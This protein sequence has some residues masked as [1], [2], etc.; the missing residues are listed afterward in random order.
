WR[1]V[2]FVVLAVPTQMG[3]GLLLAVMLDRAV[4]GRRW[5]RTIFFIPMVVSAV[6]A[7]LI[8]KWMLATT[9]LQG[10]VPAVFHDVG[11]GFPDWQTASGLWAMI[12]VV[13][14]NTWKSA[15]FCMVLYLAGLQSIN[16][17]VREAARVD[18]AERPW[19]QFRHITWPLLA[20]TTTLLLI[21][22]TMGS[23]KAFEQFFIMTSGG[24]AGATTTMV[25]YVWT[26]FP[27]LMGLASAATT[28]MM[29]GVF[30]IT[31]VQYIA[32][33]RSESYL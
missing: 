23:F 33:R 22:T 3:L 9:P 5:L 29:V 25:Y 8:F 32:T 17:E 31:V 14:M 16:A 18:G 24:P 28:M 20:P 7:G 10:L 15:G 2:L 1:T 21:T 30:A 26:K 12:I 6:A 11:L 13:I 19:Q 4:L 27:D